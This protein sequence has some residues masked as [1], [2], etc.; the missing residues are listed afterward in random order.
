MPHV[1][2]LDE[3]EQMG[4]PFLVSVGLHAGVAACLLLGTV[5]GRGNVENWGEEAAYGGS[6]AVKTTGEGPRARGRRLT[7]SCAAPSA[8]SPR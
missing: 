6:V 4:R 3:Q 1:D 2:I 8:G 7:P 5:V